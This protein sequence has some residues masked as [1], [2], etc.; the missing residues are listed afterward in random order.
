MLAAG[1]PVFAYD[2]AG[3]CD[4]LP[5]D[6]LL[7]RGARNQLALRVIETLQ[8]PN[9]E[10]LNLSNQAIAVSRQ[11][12]WKSIAADTVDCYRHHLAILRHPS[13]VQ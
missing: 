1:L 10:W 5:P 3:P 8:A 9:D 12:N 7:K 6:W 2:V 11:F 13:A 4:I